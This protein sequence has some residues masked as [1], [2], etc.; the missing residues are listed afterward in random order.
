[1]FFSFIFALASLHASGSL[2]Y[3]EVQGVAG[4]SS[5]EDGAVFH[6]GHAHD[7]MQ[8]NGIGFDFFQKF[9]G[10]YGDVATGAL[11]M[12]LV[13]DD[14]ENKPEAQIYNAYLKLKTSLADIW[15]GHNRIPYGLS[16]WMDTHAELLQPLSMAGFGS[17]RD[18]GAGVTR[19]FENGDVAAAFSLGSGMGF[20]LKGNWL[21]TARGS[22]GVL[23][24]DNRAIG[25]SFMG[26]KKLETMGYMI[27]EDEPKNTAL[28]GID[29]AYNHGDF[30]HK[31][32]LAYGRKNRREAMAALYRI[33]LSVLEEDRLKFEG[34]GVFTKQENESNLVLGLGAVCILSADFTARILYQWDR[35]MRD[36]RI[37]LQLYYYLSLL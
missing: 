34:Q 6:S 30:E 10:E 3:L 29:F 26:G 27:V 8:K 9:S 24:R 7:T 5:M 14:A 22:L 35:E 23:A 2:L 4:Y 37:I 20:R 28:G 17:D 11:Q 33:S 15:A 16:S 13:W 19:D 18:W 21:A 31:A 36:D 12:R 1:V 32:E 25:F